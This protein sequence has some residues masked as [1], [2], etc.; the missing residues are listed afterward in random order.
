M[1][2]IGKTGN[3][4]MFGDVRLKIDYNA[5]F[6]KFFKIAEQNFSLDLMVRPTN[7]RIW[8]FSNGMI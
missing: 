6:S 8:D 1:Y 5:E 3:N 4:M 2:E 7:G